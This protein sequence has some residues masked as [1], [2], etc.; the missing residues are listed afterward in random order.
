MIKSY[1]HA[2]VYTDK[3]FRAKKLNLWIFSANRALIFI[4]NVVN[5]HKL[6]SYFCAQI[7]SPI[8]LHKLTQL[9]RLKG[10]YR[11]DPSTIMFRHVWPTIFVTVCN[12]IS[13]NI[14]RGRM[15]AQRTRSQ[16]YFFT[17]II[18]FQC[19]TIN[20]DC[21]QLLNAQRPFNTYYNTFFQ[22]TA[23]AQINGFFSNISCEVRKYS[24]SMKHYTQQQ[25]ILNRENDRKAIDVPKNSIR[26]DSLVFANFS[27]FINC[28]KQLKCN[29]GAFRFW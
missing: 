27:L 4:C 29:N 2:Q 19:W 1:P 25:P 21:L 18:L 28:E 8:K 11:K 6:E 10:N 23:S 24:P 14:F 5:E 7:Q 16:Q 26:T 12:F 9:S 20:V 3:T 22:L 17:N 13:I 15:C